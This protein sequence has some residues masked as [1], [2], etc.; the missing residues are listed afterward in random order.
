MQPSE[1]MLKGKKLFL[2][3]FHIQ[4]GHESNSRA[5]MVDRHAKVLEEALDLLN[6]TP[7]VPVLYKNME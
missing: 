3:P 7:W 1:K 5:W 6:T 4:T 2:F